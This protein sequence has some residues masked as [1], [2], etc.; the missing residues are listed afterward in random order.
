MM[1]VDG[2]DELIGKQVLKLFN[3]QMQKYDLLVAYSNSLMMPGMVGYSYPYPLK[4]I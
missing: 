2:S 3:A 1:V 4:V